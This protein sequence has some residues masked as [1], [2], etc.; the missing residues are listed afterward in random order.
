[1][2]K[3]LSLALETVNGVVKPVVPASVHAETLVV[4]EAGK[5]A[6][7]YVADPSV[8]H[9]RRFTTRWVSLWDIKAD[10]LTPGNRLLLAV[11]HNIGLPDGS[12]WV[13]KKA[14]L[15]RDWNW[16]IANGTRN[17]SPFTRRTFEVKTGQPP[18]D[19]SPENPYIIG[20][21]IFTRVRP[22]L[23]SL[24]GALT[25]DATGA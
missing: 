6:T 20:P 18:Q 9:H 25:H 11:P 24:C 12:D 17:G 22:Y 15:W 10:P 13:V 1:M 7:I 23:P 19:V 2:A 14:E 8:Q 5:H 4:R 3:V 16:W 21:F